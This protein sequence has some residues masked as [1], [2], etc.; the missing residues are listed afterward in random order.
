MFLV[1]SVPGRHPV[2]ENGCQYGHLRVAYLLHKHSAPINES[3]AIVAQSSSLGRFGKGPHDWLFGNFAKSFRQDS[4]GQLKQPNVRIIYPTYNNVVNSHDGLRGGGCLPYGNFIHRYQRWLKR[5]LFQWHAD[6]R[7]RTKAMPHVKSYCRWSEKKLFW[8]I[9]TSANLSKTAWGTLGKYPTLQ[10]NNY[11]AG[12]IFLPKF[13]TNTSY[14]SMDE[15]DHSTPIFPML[16]DIPLTKYAN[17]DE[18]F[19]C[20]TVDE[21]IDE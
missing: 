5:F 12:I 1:A 20:D 16:Y 15:S 3:S 14:F 19:L 9:L 18:P 8:F 4:S 7:C 21:E 10:M 17:S 13:L 6:G 2:N 11:E